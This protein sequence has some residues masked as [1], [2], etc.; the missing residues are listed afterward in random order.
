PEET[1]LSVRR[2]WEEQPQ[3]LSQVRKRS[4]ALPATLANGGSSL[5][6]ATGLP[7]GAGW[8][9]WLEDPR[10][11]SWTAS[12]CAALT[13]AGAILARLPEVETGSG[14]RASWLDQA[15]F[16]QRMED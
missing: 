2:P 4:T 8:L 11:R 12:E 16:E 14:R 7:E 10:A 6:T 3:L 15:R 5:L 13:L 9:L 1:S